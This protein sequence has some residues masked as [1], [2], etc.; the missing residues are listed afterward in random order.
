MKS[1]ILVLTA[2]ILAASAGYVFAG[3]GACG[4]GGA[5]KTGEEARMMDNKTCLCGMQLTDDAS[6]HV[7]HNGKTYHLCST[8]CA[9]KFKADPEAALKKMEE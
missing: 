8:D 2:V 3:C 6:V 9:A 5:A 4:S 7:E 1:K